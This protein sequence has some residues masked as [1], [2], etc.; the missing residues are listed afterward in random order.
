MI[1]RGKASMAKRTA[2]V[3]MALGLVAGA[4]S[5]SSGEDSESDDSVA[6]EDDAPAD[7]PADDSE[8][9]DEPADSTDTTDEPEEVEQT[10]SDGSRLQAVIDADVVRCGG[11]ETLPGFGIVDSDGAYSGFDIDYCRVVAAAVLG[12]AEKVEVVPLNADARFPSLQSGDVDVL[13]RNTT[14]T[15]SRDGE[16]GANFLFT[17]FY[18][19]QGMMVPASTGFTAL[20]DLADAS[21][22]VLSG[23]TTELNLTSVFN[24]RGIPFTPVVFA[25]NTALQPAYESGQCEAWTSDA[26]QLAAFKSSIEGEGGEEQFIMAEVI[27]KEPL[28]PVVADGDTEWAQAVNWAVMSTVQ[29]W[30]FGLDSSN[31]GSYSGD[32]PSILAF[33]GQAE[34]PAAG[35]GLPDDFAVQVVSQVGNY[36][37][38]YNEHIVPI[39]L[40]LEGSPNDLWTN[41]GLMYVPPFR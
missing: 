37:E 25:D 22:C 9:A 10:Q 41:G 27:S 24:A 38:I 14:W 31:I 15:A 11:N 18:D 35:I 7:E 21:I 3:L 32:D 26:S 29:A 33:T 39:G 40:S 1:N 8:P 30:E 28:G 17:T 5:S 16:Q 2:G 20:E 13:I 36:E 12:D 34:N 6:T 4:C 23:T 19:G